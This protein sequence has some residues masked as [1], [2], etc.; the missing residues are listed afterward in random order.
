MSDRDYA[1]EL[2]TQAA[3]VLEA[4]Q[5][6]PHRWQAHDELCF[7]SIAEQGFDVIV[8]PE[9]GGIAVLT[10]VGFH[11]RF[12]G[13]PANAVEDALGFT[14]DLLS[15]DMRVREQRS[16]TR[17]Y[18]WLVER[19][20]SDHW[21]VEAETGLLFWNYLGRR[22]ERVY[23]NCQLSGRLEQRGSITSDHGHGAG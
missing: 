18:R 8:R 17:P 15:P 9:R 6:L 11:E 14:R 3:R 20:D 4:H 19:R 23:Q 1:T 2:R 22:S 12:D 7:P 21:C 13:A 5:T 16:G 10:N